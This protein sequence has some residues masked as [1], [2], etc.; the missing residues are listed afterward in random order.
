MSKLAV[1]V[2]QHIMMITIDDGRKN[3]MSAG[4][5]SDF[6]AAIAAAA[7]DDDVRVVL[8]LATGDKYWCAGAAPADRADAPGV[9]RDSIDRDWAIRIL[10]IDK[11]LI[12]AVNGWAVGGGFS[13]CLLHDVRIGSTR[14]R[15]AA[16]FITAGIGPEYASSLTLPHAI[17]Q[18]A[19]A[20]LLISGRQVEAAE[21]SQLGLLNAVVEPDRLNVHALEYAAVLAGHSPVAVAA[22]K[23]ALLAPLRR[24]LAAQS[25]LEW[26][27]QDA[28]FDA[29]KASGS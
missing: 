8:T 29:V 23:N 1:E 19:A 18:A 4:L 28:C 15:F 3:S 22:T 7:V 5:I 25:E 21:A 11:P 2:R 9:D 16:G 13:L 17:G 20:D 26:R 14:A 12:A 6:G 24:E 27:N 10:S